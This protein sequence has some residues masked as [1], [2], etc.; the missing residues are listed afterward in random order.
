[1]DKKE[2]FVWTSRIGPY[3]RARVGRCRRKEVGQE[4]RLRCQLDPWDGHGGVSTMVVGG[5]RV[6]WAI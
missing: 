1:V 6:N 5:S 4:L 2:Y 3:L